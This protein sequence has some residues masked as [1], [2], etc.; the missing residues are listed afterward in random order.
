[1]NETK[2]HEVLNNCYLFL[3]NL[4]TNFGLKRASGHLKR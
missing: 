2:S 1:L 3:S 4:L